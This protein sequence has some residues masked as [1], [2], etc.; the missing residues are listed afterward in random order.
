[1]TNWNSSSDSLWQN[2]VIRKLTNR[3]MYSGKK[4]VAE[5]LVFQAMSQIQGRTSKNALEVTLD[6]IEMIKPYVEVRS[7]RVAGAT[8]AV[9]V[10]IREER[11]LSLALRWLVENSR[12]RK[13]REMSQKLAGEILD[14]YLKTSGS[15]KKKEELHKMA[16]SN[17][18]FSHYR[19]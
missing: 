9:P 8:Y 13:E 11:R 17:R 4:S 1:M 14:T 5:K 16:E 18:A 10:E 2:E 15:L 3:L 19:W 6:A 7:I 12:K